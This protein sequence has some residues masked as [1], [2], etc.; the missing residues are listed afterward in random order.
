MSIP[1]VLPGDA[2]PW[3]KVRSVANERF[4]FDTCAGRYLLLVFLGSAGSALGQAAMQA[5]QARKEVFNGFNAALFVVSA[6]PADEKSNRLAETGSIKTFWDFGHD[7]ARLYGVADEQQAFGVTPTLFLVDYGLRVMAVRPLRSAED[8]AAMVDIVTR[9][10]PIPAPA[11]AAPQAPVLVVEHVFEPALCRVLIDTYEKQGAVDSGYMTQI[12]DKTVGVVD[13]GHKRRQDCL[14]KDEGLMAATRGRILRRLVPQIEKA[15]QFKVTRMERYIV[16]CYDAQIGG[17]FR[18]HRD[19]TT[20]GTAHRRFAVTINL[21]TEEYQGGDLRFPEYGSRL[22]RAPTGGAVVF[23]CGILHEATA[24]TSGRRYA[25]LPF[26]YDEA[27]AEIRARNVG[28]IVG[29]SVRPLQDEV[30]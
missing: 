6:D 7:V 10:P 17:Y 12:G 4:H 25:F 14:I 20:T 13:Y 5:L 18:P 11:P 2:A 21:N 23:S 24:V 3:F 29:S 22:F 19:N 28:S 30:S 15:Y 27:A 26:L 16:A 9:L 1:T 8:A